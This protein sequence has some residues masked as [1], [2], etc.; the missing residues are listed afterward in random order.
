MQEIRNIPPAEE[1]DYLARFL[2]MGDDVFKEVRMLSGGERTR[3]SVA[4]LLVTDPNFLVLDEP[5]THLDIPSREALEIALDDYAGTLLVVS[6]DRHLI[7]RLADQLLI[8]E[9]GAGYLFPGRFEEWASPSGPAASPPGPKSKE[10]PARRRFGTPRKK[11][12]DGTKANAASGFQIDPERK[13]AGLETHLAEVESELQ[14]ASERRDVEKV[15]ALGKE[16][17][18]VRLELEQAWEEWE[19]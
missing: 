8:V 10:D 13:I 2:F 14:S 5:T 19:E 17:D 16:Y 6:H 3:L 9:D 1:R 11:P 4:R 7:S 12:K 15:A 18:Q